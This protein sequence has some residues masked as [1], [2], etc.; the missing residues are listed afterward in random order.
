MSDALAREEP[1]ELDRLRAAAR[2]PW[3]SAATFQ[4]VLDLAGIRLAHG[5]RAP[6]MLAAPAADAPRMVVDANSA[7]VDYDRAARRDACRISAATMSAG[8]P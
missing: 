2:R 7:W 6:S 5:P 1:D 8:A 4:T 3:Q